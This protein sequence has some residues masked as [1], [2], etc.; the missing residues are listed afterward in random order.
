ME[1]TLTI[2]I[3]K[4][5][6][7]FTKCFCW[8]LIYWLPLKMPLRS[9]E[10]ERA[11]RKDIFHLFYFIFWVTFCVKPVV[12]VFFCSHY[13]LLSQWNFHIKKNEQKTLFKKGKQVHFQTPLSWEQNGQRHRNRNCFK[14]LANKASELSNQHILLWSLRDFHQSLT[15]NL[16]IFF[17]REIGNSDPFW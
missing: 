10:T 6:I 11:R 9:S 5:F 15:R 2:H 4:G 3:L 17:W 1:G 16:H 12:Q 14:Q 8:R 13:F 7:N